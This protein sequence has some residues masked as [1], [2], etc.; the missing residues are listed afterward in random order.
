MR[1]VVAE[2][3]KPV[4]LYSIGK[5]SSVMLHLA[6]KAF[7]PGRLPFP[8]L[9]I[10]TLWKF[11]DMIRFRDE[12]AKALGVELMVH[13]NR[14]GVDR[15]VD[16]AYETLEKPDLVLRTVE[17]TADRLADRVIAQLRAAGR[18]G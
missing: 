17:E 3:R 6:L 7:F 16:S 12:R 1:E 8:L 14:E 18:I 5:D 9:H 2:F 10:D 11:R 15:G 4:L 13:V